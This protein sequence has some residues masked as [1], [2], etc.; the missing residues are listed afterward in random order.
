MLRAVQPKMFYYPSGIWFSHGFVDC[1]LLLCLF[2][3]FV[4]YVLHRCLLHGFVLVMGNIIIV[5][6]NISIA[7][8]VHQALRQV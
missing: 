6:I 3:G 7:P 5:F 4:D 1:M 8:T 2:H